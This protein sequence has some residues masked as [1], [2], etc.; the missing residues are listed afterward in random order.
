MSFVVGA[1][2]VEALTAA[3]ALGIADF[4]GGTVSRSLGAARVAAGAQVAGLIGLCIVVPFTHPPPPSL[5]TSIL[6][7][8]AGVLAGIGVLT[9][10]RGLASGSMGIVSTLTGVGSIAIPLV[11]GM[12]VSQRL[13]PG[14][15]L[16]GV[17]CAGCAGVLASSLGRDV[18]RRDSLLLALLAA[19]S[20]GVAFVLISVAA[21]GQPIWTLV[22][23][24]CGMAVVLVGLALTLK[25]HHQIRRESYWHWVAV[26]GLLDVGATWL[27]IVALRQM[28]VG[29]VAAITGLYPVVTMILARVVLSEGLPLRGYRGIGLGWLGI[30]LISWGT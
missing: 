18:I 23:M 10:Y 8:L 20:F 29:L 30:I 1:P 22:F 26:A 9:L 16:L 21:G 2:V 28:Q 11:F 17:L 4:A 3:F 5:V 27:F 13:L 15:Q 6:A 14:L 25:Q 24:R 19:T 12:V 7:L